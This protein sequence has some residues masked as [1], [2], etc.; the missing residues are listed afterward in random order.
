MVKDGNDKLSKPMRL[1]TEVV[2]VTLGL[3]ATFKFGLEGL[4][5]RSE[6]LRPLVIMKLLMSYN[7]VTSPNSEIYTR[8]S[9]MIITNHRDTCKRLYSRQRMRTVHDE[10]AICCVCC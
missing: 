6:S 3:G 1:W 4:W 5:T 9:H 10:L 7:I 2:A 8:R